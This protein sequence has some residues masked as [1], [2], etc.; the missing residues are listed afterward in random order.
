M[1]EPARERA[2]DTLCGLSEYLSV[3][4]NKFNPFS[5][6]VPTQSL[7]DTTEG[8]CR[9]NRL[10]ELGFAADWQCLQRGASTWASRDAIDGALLARRPWQRG[11]IRRT[12]EQHLTL[13]FV[14]AHCL[15]TCVAVRAHV[16]IYWCGENET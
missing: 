10:A 13:Y 5:N 7:H 2:A 15:A 6:L 11:S 8:L 14:E 3:A 1:S 9:G 4:D 12:V 16:P